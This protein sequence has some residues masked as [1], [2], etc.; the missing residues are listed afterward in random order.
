MP[1]LSTFGF[2]D[3]LLSPI[4]SYLSGVIFFSGLALSYSS[5]QISS[6]LIKSSSLESLDLLE[7]NYQFFFFYVSLI[8]LFSKYILLVFM[9]SSNSYE[10]KIYLGTI[11]KAGALTLVFFR[12]ELL[13]C[14]LTSIS[15][16][17]EG[18]VFRLCRLVTYYYNLLLLATT[19]TTGLPSLLCCLYLAEHLTDSL[20]QER[21]D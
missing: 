20:Q 2:S 19:P 1:F 15:L 4:P 6:I 18:R 5:I 14:Y 12:E 21:S 8:Q 17:N 13:E 16:G 7:I 11:L 9:H 3:E 10:S